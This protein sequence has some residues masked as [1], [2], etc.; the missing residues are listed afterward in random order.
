MM[1]NE[2]IAGL[3]HAYR[4]EIAA[5]S[6]KSLAMW[7][8]L[9]ESYADKGDV[10]AEAFSGSGTTFVAAHETGRVCHGMEI[11]P[12]YAAVVIERLWLLGLTPALEV[13]A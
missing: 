3:L 2:K 8:D 10:V 13:Q 5:R 11:E 4:A 7:K 9:I 6:P 1:D 12:K